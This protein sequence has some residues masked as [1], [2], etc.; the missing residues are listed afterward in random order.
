[1]HGPA[2][3]AV[4]EVQGLAVAIMMDELSLSEPLAASGKGPG[5]TRSPQLQ[6]EVPVE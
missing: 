6:L 2:V 1:M 3:V 4:S 5:E